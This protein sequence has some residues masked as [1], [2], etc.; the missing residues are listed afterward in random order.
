[1]KIDSFKYLW[2]TFL[3]SLKKYNPFFSNFEQISNFSE[4]ERNTD[5]VI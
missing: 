5:I 2:D 4:E 3:H 1:M